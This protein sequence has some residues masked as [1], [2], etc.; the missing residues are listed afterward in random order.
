MLQKSREL[1]YAVIAMVFITLGYLLVQGIYG[2]VPSASSLWGHSIGIIGFLLMLMT[3]TLY[4]MRKRS[5]KAYWGKMSNWLEFH[6][7]TGLV[8]PYMVLLHPGWQFKGLAG[9]LSLLTILIVISGFIGRY[10]YTAIPRTA[11]GVEVDLAALIREAEEIE[12]RLTAFTRLE[13]PQAASTRNFSPGGLMVNP[14]VPFSPAENSAFSGSSSTQA[15]LKNSPKSLA[16]L[17]RERN[18]LLRDIERRQKARKVFSLWHTIHIPL[19]LT[20]FLI[21]FIH[22]GAAIYYAVLLK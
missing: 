2:D 10:I 12:N 16:Q 1:I 18:Q 13:H 11:D 19:G 20:L 22:I 5:R 9:V 7:F 3:E 14:T 4:S 17:T 15:Q 8:G 6:I 21:A